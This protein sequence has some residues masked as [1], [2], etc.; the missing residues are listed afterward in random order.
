[1]ARKHPGVYLIN[2]D[3]YRLTCFVAGKQ[4]ERWF[5]G[6]LKDAVAARAAFL[7]EMRAT[8]SRPTTPHFS[9]VLDRY[10]AAEK[11]RLKASTW[12]QK[13]HYLVTLARG[14]GD[15]PLTAFDQ[16]SVDGFTDKRRAA[17]LGVVSINNELR[18]LNRVLNWAR[19]NGYAVPYRGAKQFKEPP[20]AR[21]RF[22]TAPQVRALIA[23]AK[24]IA[25]ESRGAGVGKGGVTPDI[26][27][28]IRFL[29]HTGCRKGEV[30]ALTW[31]S[32]DLNARVVHIETQL[33]DGET[34]TPKSGRART[35]PI[36]D[37][38]LPYLSAPRKSETWVFPGRGGKRYR[39]FP[40]K[41]FAAALER[42]RLNGSVHDLR[43]TF[44]SHFLGAGQPLERLAD[45][46]GH[47]DVVVTRRYA[48]LMPGH[49]ETARNVVVF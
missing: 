4:H 16:N 23:A 35:V 5:V 44:A 3:K 13:A 31:K 11:P 47:A 9:T 12:F 25:S 24:E 39:A 37:P 10:K 27:E 8:A 29:V 41:P 43:H 1:M 30:V 40:R 34:W 17:G 22:W 7:S 48:H 28:M 6:G 45:I 42:A 18:A 19:A 33:E 14:F 21:V 49:L 32:V 15:I 46:L 26:S 2:P 20:P 36:S 38:L